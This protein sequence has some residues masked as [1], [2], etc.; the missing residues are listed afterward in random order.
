MKIKTVMT[1]KAI[2]VIFFGLGF[3]FLAKTLMSLYG[4]SVDTGGI[5]TAR[6]LGQMYILI[7]FLLWLCRNT[8][9]PS[10]K[11]AFA[12]SVT[13]GDAIGTVVCLLAVLDGTMNAMGWSAVA[14]YLVLT[15]GFGYFL[16]KPEAA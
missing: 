6:L 5:I 16:I 12:I 3:L 13:I 7:A 1:V 14:I 4:M 9:D 10:I 15:L 11:K 8:F 2:V